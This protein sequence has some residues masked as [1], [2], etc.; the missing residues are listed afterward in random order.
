DLLVSKA[1]YQDKNSV[2]WIADRRTDKTQPLK[3]PLEWDASAWN[4][5]L[6][7]GG[8]TGAKKP[9]VS[10]AELGSGEFAVPVRLEGNFPEYQYSINRIWGG[11]TTRTVTVRLVRTDPARVLRLTAQSGG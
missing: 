4:I 11:G 9:E 6:L 2:Y 8:P 5:L 3:I 1:D 10:A 7:H